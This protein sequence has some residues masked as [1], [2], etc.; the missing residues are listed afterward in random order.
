MSLIESCQCELEIAR[1]C[2]QRQGPEICSCMD[3]T[4]FS[5]QLKQDFT[6]AYMSTL[7]D[8]SSSTMDPI[9]CDTS[10]EAICQVFATKYSCCCQSEIDDYRQ[11][12]V[13]TVLPSNAGITVKCQRQ[14]QYSCLEESGGKKVHNSRS[15]PVLMGVMI[16]GL[17]VLVLFAAGILSRVLYQRRH[18]TTT[19]THSHG[20]EKTEDDPKMQKM[21]QD[22]SKNNDKKDLSNQDKNKGM[23]NRKTLEQ[24]KRITWP[25]ILFIDPFGYLRK[26]T[27]SWKKPTGSTQTSIDENHKD[28]IDLEAGHYSSSSAGGRSLSSSLSSS[29]SSSSSSWSLSMAMRGSSSILKMQISKLTDHDDESFTVSS[30]SDQ[31]SSISDE[32]SDDYDTWSFHGTAILERIRLKAEIRKRLTMNRH[33]QNNQ[34]KSD[35]ADLLGSMPLPPMIL[36]SPL[37]SSYGVTVGTGPPKIIFV[38]D[39][40]WDLVSR[41]SS[42]SKG[43]LSPLNASL[44]R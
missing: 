14:Q 38:P 23:Q 35:R 43:R 19:H 21:M 13:E 25:S 7:S 3:V 18:R 36:S 6:K 24:T 4:T 15:S 41:T 20:E 12:L 16:T 5:T 22:D 26:S 37:P 28:S 10:N 2:I 17:L 29:S 27:T 39:E 9:W 30:M 34:Q 32:D 1:Q 31:S 33:N 8:V 44:D 40:A 42:N 11:C